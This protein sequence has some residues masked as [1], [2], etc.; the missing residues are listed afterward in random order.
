MKKVIAFII[1]L[2]ID[3]IG[4]FGWAGLRAYKAIVFD[5]ECKGHMNRAAD[6]NT[7]EL[8]RQEMEIV[9]NYLEKN[10]MTNGYTSVLFRTPNEDVGFFYKNMKAS[11]AELKSLK[12]D[13]TPLEKSN[14]LMKLRETLS[15]VPPGIEVFPYNAA[16]AISGIILGI[17]AIIGIII[18]LLL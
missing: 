14:L 16:Y 9:V 7:V 5:I 18:L 6:A 11:L 13:A 4:F 1:L 10:G 2:C 17:F 15:T 8:A 12:P 3:C